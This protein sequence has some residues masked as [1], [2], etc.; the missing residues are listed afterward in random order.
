VGTVSGMRGNGIRHAWERVG[1]PRRGAPCLGTPAA[2]KL[3]TGRGLA[4]GFFVGF[5]LVFSCFFARAREDRPQ[6]RMDK[7]FPAFWGLS[8]MSLFSG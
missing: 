7:G 5:F 6:T 2:S 8:K 1:E 4:A 3:P